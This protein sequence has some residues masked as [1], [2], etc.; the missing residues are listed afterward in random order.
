MYEEGKERR[1][2][3]PRSLPEREGSEEED[4]RRRGLTGQWDQEGKR[5][6]K[7]EREEGNCFIL[8]VEMKPEARRSK[9][10]STSTGT[11]TSKES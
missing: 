9:S 4:E 7:T 8:I 5:S 10:T 6:T 2:R 3:A 1:E 11:D